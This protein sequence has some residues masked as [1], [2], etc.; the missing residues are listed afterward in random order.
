MRVL[1][2]V[3]VLAVLLA[4]VP[5]TSHAGEDP[6]PISAHFDNTDVKQVLSVIAKA[7]EVN[8]IMSPKVKG[9]IT[10]KLESVPWR[11]ALDHVAAT[12]GAKVIE[13]DFG[14]LRVVPAAEVEAKKAEEKARFVELQERARKKL[15]AEQKA[16]EAHKRALIAIEKA[17]AD[18]ARKAA[19]I[20]RLKKE[21]VVQSKPSFRTD[22]R[23]PVIVFGEDGKQKPVKLVRKVS[24]K[25]GQVIWVYGDA[26]KGDQIL[27]VD[28]KRLEGDGK[29]VKTGNDRKFRVFGLK[30]GKY[31]IQLTKKKDGVYVATGRAKAGKKDAAVWNS[32]V[33]I[34]G[35]AGSAKRSRGGKAR[36]KVTS[37]RSVTAKSVE[38][39][40]A[41]KRAQD[42]EA[43]AKHLKAAGD[44]KGAQ[45]LY[46]RA[47]EA[48][49]AAK[50]HKAREGD[51]GNLLHAVN[52]LRRDVNQLRGEVRELTGLVRQLLGKRSTNRAILLP[53][54]GG[55]GGAFFGR[56][57][58]EGA[59][60]RGGAGG[61][62]GGA[63]GDG[64]TAR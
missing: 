48:Y 11:A 22:G 55:R 60:G 8:L 7:A 57:P 25:D 43:A 52:A 1:S 3:A 42:L 47:K 19:E 62:G 41:F 16:I 2:T 4:T 49:E 27:V 9:T 23:P 58:P 31:E 18:A 6:T 39:L 64:G 26:E 63:G 40:K 5:F 59:G 12:V 46:R 17:R 61:E 37:T 33:G 32:T 14:I 21:F 50:R 38:A 15:A 45:D 35:R 30:D 28:G 20:E 56:R 44:E 51:G 54:S 10:L 36:K 24:G 29:V 13:E 53:G 34:A